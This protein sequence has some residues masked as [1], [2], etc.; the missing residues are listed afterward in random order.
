MVK[1]IL[2]FLQGALVSIGAALPG[3][4]GGVMCVLFG[5]YKPFMRFLAHPVREVRTNAPQILPLVLGYLIGYVSIAGVISDIM[6]SHFRTQAMAAFIG[7]TIGILPSLFREAGE[8]GRDRKSWLSLGGVFLAATALLAF[9]KV[10]NFVIVPNIGWNAFCG[11]ALALA[12]IAPGLSSSVVLMP[13]RVEGM[14]KAE[15]LV[16]GVK[17]VVE[18]PGT[19]ELYTHTMSA[20]KN[21]DFS[22][23]IP[24]IIGAV[25]TILLLSKF[26]NWLLETHYSVVFH[27]IVGIVVASTIFVLIDA[28]NSHTIEGGGDPFGAVHVILIVTCAVAALLLEHVN[29]KVKKPEV[30]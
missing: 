5:I 17:T 30:D 19:I 12:I 16:D 13:L 6:E 21:A 3:V 25:A 26:I 11:V 18:Q 9:L 27:G 10:N 22:A 8:Q 24:V 2:L 7:L 29:Q 20:I 14:V 4:S 23:L 28:I 1:I 15:Q